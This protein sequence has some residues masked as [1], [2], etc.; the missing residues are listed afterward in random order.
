LKGIVSDILSDLPLSSV[1]VLVDNQTKVVTDTN[2]VFKIKTL[3]GKHRIRASRLGYRIYESTFEYDYDGIREIKI[4]LEPFVNQLDQFVVAGSRQQ[5]KVSREVM[6]V[7]V[8]QPYLVSSTNAGDLSDVVNKIPGVNIVEGQATIRGGVGYS[9]NTGSRVALLL[10]DMP[11]LGADLGDIRWKFLP[12]EAAEQIEVIKGSASV[13]YGS[14]ALN[15]TINV[16]TG[17]AGKKPQTKFQF[18][19][20]VF[21]NFERSYINWWEYSTRPFTSSMFFS[22]KQSFDNFD[23]VWCGNLLANRSHLQFADEF[24]GR[25]YIKTRYRDPSVPGLTYGIN[26]NMMVEQSGRFFLWQNADTG[27]LKQLNVSKPIDDQFRIFSLDPHLNYLKDNYEHSV[28]MRYYQIARLVDKTRY[29]GEQDALANLYALDYNYRLNF[30]KNFRLNSGIYAT[31]MWAQGNVYKGIFTGY[32]TA[33]YAN[34]DYK[35]KRWNFSVGSRFEINN[36]A[37]QTE[38]TGFLKR[39]G[40]NYQITSNTFFRTNYSEGYRFPTV[41]E[42]Y[43]ED[44]VSDL[45]V[46][47]NPALASEKGWTAEA[48]IQQGFKIG[49]FFASADLAFFVQEYDSMIE[50]R[51][52]QWVS[53]IEKPP[54]GVI[55]FKAF[56]IGQTR[57]G[58]FD[59]SLTGEGK[60]SDLMIRTIAGYTLSYPVN[61]SKDPTKKDFGKY[62]YWFGQSLNGIDSSQM[63]SLL[64]YRNR[65]IGKIDLELSYHKFSAGYALL[66]YSVYE[67]VD[68]FI[69]LLPGVKKFF[70][71][72]ENGDF[73]HNFRIAFNVSQNFTIAA[74]V[75]NATNR[76]YATRPGK[77]D[78][79][80][81][82]HVQMRYSF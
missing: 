70:E 43:V 11:L 6:S 69:L 7:N 15:G 45:S 18:S 30:F 78:P 25:T 65:K 22:H 62:L 53:A 14:A 63:V 23:I 68:P 52:G 37:A 28:K 75:N 73:I 24:R 61:L 2:G 3:P 1:S 79:P 26:S 50:F 31:T 49:D 72:A 13:L 47:P 56:N 54:M 19:Q 9:Y 60:I 51:F 58:G 36:L 4:E 48:G 12:I 42:K 27:A 77:M 59:F 39:L 71:R 33:A 34:L 64:P 44:R 76:E 67:K 74:L 40:L 5:K 8:I 46:L 21:Q 41:G 10:D 17:W 16:R 57:I 80:R 29:P 35:I 66:Y 32:S 82:F 55:G 20:G 81:S 38:N